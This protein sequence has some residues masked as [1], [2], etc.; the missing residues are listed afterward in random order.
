M[1]GWHAE[2]PFI[3]MAKRGA[4]A[5]QF[6]LPA[7]DG[8][9]S[10]E[11]VYGPENLA[12]QE[13]WLMACEPNSDSVGIRIITAAPEITGVR[14]AMEEAIK[15][16]VI[17]SI[18][19]SMASTDI[20]TAAAVGGARLITHLFNAMPQLHHRDPSI[21][22]LLGASPHLSY[23]VSPTST[24]TSPIGTT[25]PSSI[26]AHKRGES[27]SS[28]AKRVLEAHG[29]GGAKATSEAFDELVTPPMTP[30]LAPIDTDLG[31]KK[32]EVAKMSFERPFYELIVD[33]IHS[34]PNSVRVSSLCCLFS[35]MLLTVS[36]SSHTPPTLKVVS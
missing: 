19:H 36:S 32:G 34:H 33:G 14:P 22:G 10:F 6:L 26:S 4:H 9:A 27:S 31:L 2:G 35:R 7:T 3:Q 24:P 11:E 1:L 29:D 21:I 17:W 5:P 18:G 13:D 15:R 8:Y 20:A 30:V 16:G 23:P 25:F 28:L 12:V